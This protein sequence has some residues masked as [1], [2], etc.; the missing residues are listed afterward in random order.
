MT[1]FNVTC[2]FKQSYRNAH[3]ITVSGDYSGIEAE[4]QTSNR[5]VLGLIPIGGTVLCP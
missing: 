1:G 5:E 4:H 2:K 3:D